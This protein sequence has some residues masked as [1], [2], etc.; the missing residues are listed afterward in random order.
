MQEL[1]MA[2][3]PH[4]VDLRVGWR[5]DFVLRKRVRKLLADLRCFGNA[6]EVAVHCCL[7]V[8]HN[9]HP[10]TRELA[11]RIAVAYVEHWKKSPEYRL[12]FERDPQSHEVGEGRILTAPAT[13]KTSWVSEGL[14][15]GL[16]E[17][18]GKAVE[19]DSIKP[20]RR[21]G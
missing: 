8:V 7:E 20:R 13:R 1:I 15:H 9:Y 12:M 6:Y 14:L 10:A 19:V 11:E 18:K 2:L 3:K 5:R 21:R 17:S 16:M 4:Q